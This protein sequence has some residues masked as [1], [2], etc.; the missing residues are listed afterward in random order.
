MSKLRQQP[1]S[2]ALRRA[3]RASKLSQYRIAKEIDISES[4]VSRFVNGHQGILMSTAD[5][6]AK[7][8]GLK[9]E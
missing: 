5:R 7:L 2:E 9:L 3:I 4:V 8:L 6:L 1:I